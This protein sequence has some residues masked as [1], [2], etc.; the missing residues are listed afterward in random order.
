L[1]GLRRYDR[2]FGCLA[3]R[4]PDM[5]RQRCSEQ[6]LRLRE[7]CLDADALPPPLTAASERKDVIDEFTRPLA[8]A[9]NFDEIGG[10]VGS[11]TR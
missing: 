8:G 4:D 5:R 6:L 11:A 1:C 2:L 10:R 9:T 7:Q 3:H